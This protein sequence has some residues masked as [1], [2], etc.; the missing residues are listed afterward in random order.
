MTGAEAVVR[1]IIEK[2][3]K[4][5]FGYPGGAILPIYDALYDSGVTHYL[6]RH[7]Q[8]A[9]FAAVGYARASGK[10]GVV[11]ATSG[12]GVANLLTALA[13]AKSDSIPLVAI[14]GQVPR[15]AMG[16]DSFQEIDTLGL[17]LPITKHSYQ[18]MNPEELPRLLNEAFTIAEEGRP[19]PV[20]IDIPKDIQLADVDFTPYLSVTKKPRI[21]DLQAINQAVALIQQAR[22]PVVYV[23]GGVHM[24][25]AESSLNTFLHK[26][27]IPAVTTLK[28][29]G[30]IAPNYPYF[31]GM[32][33]MH[34]TPAANNAIQ[35]SDLLIC[36]GARFDDRATGK[37]NTF[38]PNAKVIH[39]DIDPAEV[40]KNRTANVPLIG[41]L[42][43]TITALT[44][45][46]SISDWSLKT[47]QEKS[48]CEPD[49]SHPG[50]RIYAPLLLKQLSNHLPKNSIVSCDVGQH[51]MWV[52]QH[53]TFSHPSNHLSSGGLGT[54]GFGLPS[55]IGAYLSRPEETT[56]V[57]SGDGSFMMNI[58]ELA[59]IKR[60]NLPVK[61]IILDNSRL[62]MVRQWQQLFYD[63]RYSETD[64]SDNPDFVGLAAAFDIPGMFIDSKSQV[65]PAI[66]SMLE[67]PSAFL[68]HVH[69]NEMDN[70]WPLVPPGE[71]NHIMMT[72]DN[73]E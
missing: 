2:G 19:G 38:A 18:V 43:K 62:G 13:D 48:A 16:S 65:M 7:E 17:S 15:S 8:G 60:F 54:M 3:I 55:G 23:G 27:N 9:G 12:P 53:M 26:T 58:Q 57:I 44:T 70:V 25:K 39:L 67:T 31:L 64:L 66:D 1:I 21:A 4:H 72:G 49:Y 22:R 41:D 73:Y 59:S 50:E 32:L 33:G 56:V 46:R 40:G 63:K 61:I 14:T 11:M 68:L 69:I 51:Q 52:A 42:N 29:I 6:C 10:T 20:L 28:G 5:I 24:A 47:Q 30:T 36:I 71:A 37:L 34:G 45:T 35:Q